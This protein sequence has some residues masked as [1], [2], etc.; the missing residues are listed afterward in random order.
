[1]AAPPT[2]NICP[3]TPWRVSSSPRALSA[4]RIPAC[5]KWR[6]GTVEHL[7]GH[8]HPVARDDGRRVG[9]RVGVEGGAARDEPPGLD[10][11]LRLLDPRRC[12]N[13]ALGREELRD[14]RERSIEARVA[15]RWRL[16]L[17][18]RN[19]T[20]AAGGPE[21]VRESKQQPQCVALL[22]AIQIPTDRLR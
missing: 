19:P 4:S 2:M 10:E 13:R 9:Q 14:A 16:L 15:G 17:K 5:G 18:E 6:S 3:C 11:P 22:P 7:A 1:M 21:I 12:R 8:E 20:G